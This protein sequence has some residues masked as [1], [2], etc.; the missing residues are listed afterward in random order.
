MML[1][2]FNLP[3]SPF[4][5]RPLDYS[6]P[7]IGDGVSQ[8]AAPF[9]W[10][11]GGARL[12]PEQIA[13]EQDVA[14]A[15]LASGSDTSP[16]GHWTQGL[17]RSLNGLMGGIRQNRANKRE[18]A[19]N[20]DRTAMIAQML[21]PDNADLA[22][23]VSSGDRVLAGLAGDVLERRNPKPASPTDLQRNY[24][25]LAGQG[26]TDE[27]NALITKATQDNPWITATLPDGNFYSGPARGLASAF[28][29][30]EPEGGDRPI[31]PMPGAV[32][33]AAP[34]SAGPGT[35]HLTVDQMRSIGQGVNFS[36]WQQKHGTP[37]LVNGPE[38]MARVPAGTMV[39]S[40]DGRRGVK[41]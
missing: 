17:A 22:G 28:G 21:G 36:Q 26:R 18:E 35:P 40:P 14:A 25:W 37:V 13:R 23:A 32:G 2:P 9:V 33:S 24:E 10:G 16:V 30:N 1:G 41:K 29:S 3:Q 38:E 31:S 6:T 39:I 8:P 5:M 7:G 19:A 34:A 15:L 12:S 4:D 27:A 11:Q 20:A